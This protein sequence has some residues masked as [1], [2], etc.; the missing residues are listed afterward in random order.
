MYKGILY[1]SVNSFLAANC[2]KEFEKIR[3]IYVM[4]I[5]FHRAKKEWRMKDGK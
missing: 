1:K 3:R 5:S 2:E 4:I